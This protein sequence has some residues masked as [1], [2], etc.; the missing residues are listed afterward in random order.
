MPSIVEEPTPAIQVAPSAVLE[1]MWVLHFSQADHEHGGAFASLDPLRSRFGRQITELMSDGLAQNAAELVVLGQRSGTLLDLDLQRFFER[2]D[3]AAAERTVGP[4]LLSETPADREIV[5]ARL[6][7]LRA[8]AALRR[9]YIDLMSAVW[10]AVEPEWESVGRA[11]VVAETQRWKRE[12][13]DQGAGY[14]SVLGL[15]RLWRGRPELDDLTDAAAAEG[16]LILNPCWFGG[17]MHMIELDGTVVAGR[18][19]RHGSPS[20]RKVADEVASSI[21]AIADPTRL[22]ILLR[23]ARE[24]ASVTE[25]ARQLKLSQPT[26]SAHVDMLREAGLIDERAAGRSTELSASEE[27]LRRLFS[28]TEESLIRL[29]RS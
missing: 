29:F 22:T 16:R 19:I 1:L 15:D 25:L 21:K 26:V 14:K 11:A 2:L 3:A 18:G 13:Q 12:L 17:K 24:P 23:L 20:Y 10:E 6:E 4:T 9:R 5:R 28:R 27:G 7:R 8:D